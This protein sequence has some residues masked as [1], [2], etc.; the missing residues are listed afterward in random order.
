M[1]IE[2][3]D[4]LI[5][6]NETI[7]TQHKELISRIKQFVDTCEKEENSKIKAIKMLDYLT[8]YTNFHFS[9]EEKLQEEIGY[10]G[11]K[12]HKEKHE[13]FKKNLKELDAFLEES[14]GPTDAF[15][16]QVKSNVVDW[17]FTHIKA[18]DR[19]VAEYIFL[20]NNPN[21]L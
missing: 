2:F 20:N 10:P 18:F 14:E 6:G 16:Q 13:V 17:L 11:L 4:T 19:S 21:R 9:E 7:D 15:V 5:T 8:E 1:I 12:E 3:D